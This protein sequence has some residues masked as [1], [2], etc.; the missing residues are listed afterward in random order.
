MAAISTWASNSAECSRKTSV[1]RMARGRIEK[2]R[3]NWDFTA[4]HQ[5][6]QI[7]KQLLGSLDGKCW[8]DQC[9]VRRMRL[10]DFGGQ[11][12]TPGLRGNR[13]PFP[14]AVSGFRNDVIE[15]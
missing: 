14:F 11:G 13:S 5:V 12:V 6:D 1:A 9:T 3:S 7:D 4:L 10:E 15:S 2:D 8:N